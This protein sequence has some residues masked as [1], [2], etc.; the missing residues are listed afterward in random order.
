MIDA[1][2]GVYT[3][4]PASTFGGS[5]PFV[6]LGTGRTA[7]AI[8]VGL[9]HSCA[10]LDIA[11]IKCWI[12]NFILL[13]S[14]S[15][16]ANGPCPKPDLPQDRKI[17]LTLVQT[18]LKN[19]EAW[20]I[21]SAFTINKNLA[22]TFQ[23]AKKIESLEHIIPLINIFKL[24]ED[25]KTLEAGIQLLPGLSFRQIFQIEI[26]DHDHMM[27]LQF[28]EGSFAGLSGQVCFLTNDTNQT[29]VVVYAAGN[30]K[31]NPLPFF[32]TNSM[33]EAIS[34]SIIKRWRNHTENPE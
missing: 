12:V 5:N 20:T 25:R 27:K 33:L 21:Q 8:S 3:T 15:A 16:L 14:L 26:L 10:L 11:S 1:V 4:P 18:K 32:I 2:T 17:F 13:L 7:T 6:N 30:L 28:T 34:K 24:S 9:T 31:A 19:T 29:A 23:A 22:E